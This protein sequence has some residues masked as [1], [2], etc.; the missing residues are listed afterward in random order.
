MTYYAIKIFSLIISSFPRKIAIFIAICLGTIINIFFPKRKN[1]ARQNLMIAFPEK[2]LIDINQI[3]KKTY[4]H[5]MIL[6]IDFLRQ[7]SFDKSKIHIDSET[8]NILS[9]K[10]GF[11]FM[12][13]HI[14]NW[15][16][17]IPILN[18]YK[19]TT[20]IVKVQKNS[21]GDRFVTELR[22]FENI[23][24]LPMGISTDKMIEALHRGDVLAL[25]SDQN[26]G[27]KGIRIP[28]F[29]KEA[30]IP[31]G[32]AYFHFKT[33]LP[34]M[35]GFCILNK[36][37]TYSFKIIKITLQSKKIEDLF[38]EVSTIYTQLL[39]QEIKKNPEQYFWFHKKYDRKIYK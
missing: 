2:S 24:L 6:V 17:I 20:G 26:A 8:K 1:V 35:I 38:I 23:T 27:I 15:E 13:A 18:K 37:Y 33:H 30:S 22:S 16:M 4:Q 12:T 5:Y 7:K 25:A 32:A 39:E 36:D 29:G 3:I 9:N 21:G 14:G 31:K 11:I 19:K 10:N 34:I 28:F